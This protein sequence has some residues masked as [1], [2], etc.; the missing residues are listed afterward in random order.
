LRSSLL[1]AHQQVEA[2]QGVVECMT[3]TQRL[4]DQTREE[5]ARSKELAG[6]HQGTAAELATR[7]E[8]STAEAQTARRQV[9]ELERS[10]AEARDQVRSSQVALAEAIGEGDRLRQELQA[11]RQ[12]TDEGLRER[13]ELGTALARTAAEARRLGEE[14]EAMR[15]AER[16]RED[17]VAELER[18]QGSL[19]DAQR[20]AEDLESAVA[21]LDTRLEAATA[22][23]RSLR[24][25]FEQRLQQ[26]TESHAEATRLA[27]AVAQAEVRSEQAAVEQ[28][29]AARELDS[30]R[31]ELERALVERQRALDER[32]RLN[33]TSEEAQ[34]H[35]SDQLSKE[36]SQKAAFRAQLEEGRAALETAHGEAGALRARM[37]ELEAQAALEGAAA[38]GLKSALDEI[39]H[40][41]ARIADTQEAH[42]RLTSRLDSSE[43]QCRTYQQ[44]L[45]E[46]G[47]ECA[48]LRSELDAMDAKWTAQGEEERRLR[49]E[50]A[51]LRA[52]SARHEEA[53]RDRCRIEE[54]LDQLR[55]EGEAH[56][57]AAADLADRLAKAESQRVGLLGQH[58][59]AGAQWEAERCRADA[60][61]RDAWAE[62]R[63]WRTAYCDLAPIVAAH[64]EAS[65]RL[66]ESQSAVRTLEAE[67]ADQE[68]V[69]RELT[70]RLAAA[71]DRVRAN[72]AAAEVSPRNLEEARTE[73]AAVRG[74]VIHVRCEAKAID[75]EL[76][77][78]RPVVERRRQ[79]TATLRDVESR[80]ADREAECDRA[81]R[82]VLELAGQDEGLRREIGKLQQ[83]LSAALDEARQA[84]TL[85]N[86]LRALAADSAAKAVSAREALREVEASAG[87][88]ARRVQ[89]AEG[90][91]AQLEESLAQQSR[92]V[93]SLEADRDGLKAQ[94]AELQQESAAAR[95][96][97]NEATR[98]AEA[99][100]RTAETA[101][102]EADR[103]RADLGDAQ[104][105]L[106]VQA[107]IGA[108]AEA[109]VGEL[110][111]A[112]E[113][114]ERAAAELREQVG[115][116]IAFVAE[117]QRRLEAE[118]SR[119][120]GTRE[121]CSSLETARKRAEAEAAQGR[122][123]I[124]ALRPLA[125]RQRS[126][127]E[128][129]LAVQALHA[130]LAERLAEQEQAGAEHAAATEES[131]RSL[132]LEVQRQESIIEAQRAEADELRATAGASSK[133]RDRL[134]AELIGLRQATVDRATLSRQH[135]QDVAVLAALRQEAERHEG[136]AARL[137]DE[138]AAVQLECA[139]LRREQRESRRAVEPAIL[140][141]AA[142][143]L[144]RTME[145]GDGSG[146]LGSGSD[147]PHGGVPGEMAQALV[148][149]AHREQAVDRMDDPA[150]RA[151]TFDGSD[152]A[153]D[154]FD[155][156]VGA[157]SRFPARRDPADPRI[158]DHKA[159]PLGE[160]SDQDFNRLLDRWESRRISRSMRRVAVGT[161]VLIILLAAGTGAVTVLWNTVRQALGN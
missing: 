7:V 95:Q 103:L 126:D 55:R 148:K 131:L 52:N 45:D 141:V 57:Q 91:A 93:R 156:P 49:S 83:Q 28:G 22:G 30:V 101:R 107:A 13:E 92:A 120:R 84:A 19:A 155:P 58:A 70:Q 33:A 152:S 102:A 39:V 132:R 153:L 50:F 150:H 66:I 42:V 56:A 136:R 105:K 104:A 122:A 118:E 63:R 98:N 26:A 37:H 129:L 158:A 71:E 142:I 96:Q 114:K 117:L 4:L 12:R 74:Q 48:R 2:L 79:L 82:E 85:E 3:E 78:L 38:A 124:E 65:G 116:G 35:L 11:A 68:L 109:I 159:V 59:E 127:A 29:R 46:Q 138:L 134:A 24:V 77:T 60:A 110:Q 40:W 76:G 20:R 27:A 36:R 1:A 115:T 157:E 64:E 111:A 67:T 128:R 147:V 81:K 75:E 149:R 144:G 31:R 151:F 23:E 34:A 6:L 80:L 90:T 161:G 17:L 130:S 25:E 106:A 108:K 140:D 145:E 9:L 69:L 133:E 139:T 10:E 32:A 8:A 41:K 18:V 112:I 135:E 89:D 146:T 16:S 125:E 44:Q 113:A 123:E 73:L 54:E 143:P 43:A 5:L 119:G 154:D 121:Q 88:A 14:V 137:E 61:L 21:T 72:H 87:S 99:I 160:G 86:S 51:A 97:V 47:A 94:L 53:A 15:S 62:G 100:E